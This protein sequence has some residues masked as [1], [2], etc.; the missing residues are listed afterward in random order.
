ML[1]NEQ[2]NMLPERIYQRLN[3]INTE[4]LTSIGNVIRKINELRPKDVHQLKRLYDYGADMHRI[5]L[6]LAEVSKKNINDIYEIFD[7][8]AKDNYSSAETFYKAKNIPFIP[9]EKNEG[10]QEYVKSLAKQTVGEYVNLSQHTAFA[11]FDKGGKSIAPLFAA[12]K[13]KIATSLSNT[14]TKIVDYAVSKV[15]MGGESYGKAIKDICKAMAN[16]GIRTVDGVKKADYATGYSRRLDTA[17]RQN[18]L[19]GVKQCNQ[20]TADQIGEEFGADG[21]E[22]SYHSNPRESHAD[23]AGKQFAKG[24]ARTVNGVFYPSFEE[25]AEPLLNEFNCLHFLKYWFITFR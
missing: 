25:V 18:V 8:I 20:N 13:D 2:I 15:Q 10:L 19:W 3:N 9:Y 23:M 7:I 1:S 24:P 4:Y 22:V 11:V 17:V 5:S 14:Y 6:K 12:N 16:S 21:Y